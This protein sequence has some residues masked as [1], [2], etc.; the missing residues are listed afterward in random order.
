MGAPYIDY[1]IGDKTLFTLADAK[2]YSEKLILL[3]NSYQPNDRKRPISKKAF[4]RKGAGLPDSAFVF[5]CFN[6]NYKITSDIFDSWMRILNHVEGSVLWLFA[7]NQTAIENLR[8]EAKIRDIDPARLVFADAMDLP[9]H[10]ARHRLADLFLDTLP[11]NAHTTASDALWAGLPVL[12]RIG[13]AFPGRVAASLLNA[14]GLPELIANSCNEYEK[15]AIE[16]ALSPEKRSVIREKLT[17]NR[18]T[19]P[20]FDAP[21]YTQHVEAAYEA[22][23]QRHKTGSPPDHIEIAPIRPLP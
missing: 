21:L 13:K 8:N 14:I 12:T 11:Y 18:L 6:N 23:Y 5:C 9:D 22:M 1:I 17:N 2:F 3:P 19:T 16:F 4:T 10:L 7:E 15:L 20:L